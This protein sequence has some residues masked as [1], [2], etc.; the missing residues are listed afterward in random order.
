MTEQSAE[1]KSWVCKEC[2]APIVFSKCPSC[3]GEGSF[4]NRNNNE[5][6]CPICKGDCGWPACSKDQFH[7]GISEV[8]S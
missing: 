3:N 4:L 2:G 5:L 7:G 8:K 1:Q 6:L